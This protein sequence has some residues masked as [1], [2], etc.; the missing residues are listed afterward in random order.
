MDDEELEYFYDADTVI[1]E[2]LSIRF[3]KKKTF[4]A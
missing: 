1:L 4:V 2:K 3:K